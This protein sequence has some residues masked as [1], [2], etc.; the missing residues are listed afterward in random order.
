MEPGS[1]SAGSASNEPGRMS[2]ERM[3]TPID[4]SFGYWIADT[5]CTWGLWWTLMP[6]EIP[7]GWDVDDD[8]D[9]VRGVSP[10][11]IFE[12]LRRLGQLLPPC[13]PALPD[14]VEW[15][16]AC[17]AGTGTPW[18]FGSAVNANLVRML[19]TGPVPVASLPPNPWG[20]YEMHGNVAE[21]CVDFA[22]FEGNA[23]SAAAILPTRLS[24]RGGSFA[25]PPAAVRSA[26][27]RTIE[28]H[29]RRDD[30]GFRFVLRA[31]ERGAPMAAAL[32]DPAA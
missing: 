22:T 31:R 14:Q 2:D 10:A 12:F 11:Q 18:A 30:A 20:L 21:L 7:P 25:D 29:E 19:S 6:E 15:E 13:E 4:L 26:A 8:N 3:Q 17:R 1:F 16:Y 32:P 24:L 28:H 23:P 9:P 5:A 27:V